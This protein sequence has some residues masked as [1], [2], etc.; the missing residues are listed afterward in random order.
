MTNKNSC[1]ISAA[2]KDGR[3]PVLVIDGTG[4]VGA[5]LCQF[6]SARGHPVTAASRSQEVI[7]DDP[8][9]ERLELDVLAHS[10][11]DRL[12]SSKVAIIVPWVQQPDDVEHRPWLDRLVR[13]LVGAGTR[14]VIYVSS[15]WV[16]G[17]EP[18]GC[19]TE[20]M[21]VAPTDPYGSAH[22]ANEASL[23][24]CADGLGVDVAILRLANLVVPDP[25]FRSRTKIA[26]THEL[27]EMA[28]LNRLIEL[29]SPPSTPRNMLPGS[30]FHHDIGTLLD[31][32]PV[33]GRVETF[34]LGSASTSTMINL[35]KEI[36]VM[37]EGHH[38]NRVG[39]K[40]PEEL[41]VQPQF[42]LDTTKI[43]QI[44][45]PHVDDLSGEL[46]RILRQVV[47]VRD[48]AAVIG[49]PV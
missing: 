15:I 32:R 43:R 23:T 13:L 33:E 48:P 18:R 28:L 29:R 1:L 47:S 22:V 12:P 17:R 41:E 38:G 45:G 46:S 39:I 37:A 10:N 7:F 5:S 27:M 19:L 44:A 3:S 26:F 31:R 36:A 34:N 30:L 11:P 8:S 6:L 24:K 4:H 9:I 49:K 21:P 2:R 20:S 14:S 25:F 40:H 35:A 16:Y 42:R